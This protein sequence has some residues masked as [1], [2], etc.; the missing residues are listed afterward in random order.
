MGTRAEY[1]SPDVDTHPP[2]N[3]EYIQSYPV[4]SNP[5]YVTYIDIGLGHIKTAKWE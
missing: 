4:R 1:T 3:Q 2:W 5:V